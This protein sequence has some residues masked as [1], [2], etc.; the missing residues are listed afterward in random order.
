MNIA[1]AFLAVDE[2]QQERPTLPTRPVSEIPVRNEKHT[3]TG[4]Y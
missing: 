2:F 4:K 1:I 3:T